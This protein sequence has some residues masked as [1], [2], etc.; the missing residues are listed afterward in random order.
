ME[1]SNMDDGARVCGG[2]VALYIHKVDEG[3]RSGTLVRHGCTDC[4]TNCFIMNAR[5]GAPGGRGLVEFRDEPLA[6][7]IAPRR[8]NAGSAVQ[9]YLFT[10]FSCM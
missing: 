2:P 7:R 3:W 6:V 1:I 5:V 9:L 4:P 10:A 8:L